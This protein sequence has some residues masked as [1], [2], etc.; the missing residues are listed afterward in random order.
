MVDRIILSYNELIIWVPNFTIAL[1][2]LD[3]FKSD[4][5]F[6]EVN[7]YSSLRAS[8]PVPAKAGTAS[9]E[10]IAIDFATRSFVAHSYRGLNNEEKKYS[11]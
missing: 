2:L 5:T 10:P 8:S 7:H 3:S 9:G 1:A 11:N 4:C 6:R